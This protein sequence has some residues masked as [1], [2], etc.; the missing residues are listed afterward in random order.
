MS[1][2]STRTLPLLAPAG[3]EHLDGGD[4]PAP[5]GQKTVE[6]PAATRK[7]SWLTARTIRSRA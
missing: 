7:L 4:L 1:S 5:F 2:P 6:T 3:G